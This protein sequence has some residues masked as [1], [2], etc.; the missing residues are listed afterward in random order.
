MTDRNQTVNINNTLIYYGIATHNFSQLN[1]LIHERNS[2]KMKHELTKKDFN[3]MLENSTEIEYSAIVTVVFSL[4]TIESFINT[5]A[6]EHF[7]KSHFDKYL[8]KLDLKSKWVIYPKLIAN[9]QINTHSQ[10]FELLGDLITL[11]NRLVHAKPSVKLLR[12]IKNFKDIE[13][14]TELDA[15][16]AVNAVQMLVKELANCDPNIETEWLDWPIFK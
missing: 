14:A 2:K 5:Y 3:F 13:R 15:K 11:R 7:S 4:M 8:D 1:T 12:E 16:K 6:I 10:A 9:K